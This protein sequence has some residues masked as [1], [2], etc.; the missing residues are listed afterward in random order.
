MVLR[1]KLRV[2]DSL[3][4]FF[5]LQ[6]KIFALLIW[7]TLAAGQR[8]LDDIGGKK[9]SRV[10]GYVFLLAYSPGGTCREKPCYCIITTLV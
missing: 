8:N 5:L 10:W 2:L 4:H 7:V 3:H 1:Q 6:M 9:T